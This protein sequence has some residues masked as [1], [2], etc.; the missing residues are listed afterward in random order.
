MLVVPM[1]EV[2]KTFNVFAKKPS[3]MRMIQISSQARFGQMEKEDEA[4]AGLLA[5]FRLISSHGSGSGFRKRKLGL[6][7]DPGP[8]L[9]CS[10]VWA[11][12]DSLNL[13]CRSDNPG[14]GLGNYLEITTVDL[15]G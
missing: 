12:P 1:A 11:Y 2:S 10:A 4:S 6:L 15:G 13:L 9:C 14:V 7:S 3:L 8:V 5:Y